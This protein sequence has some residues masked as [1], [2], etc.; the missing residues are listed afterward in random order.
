MYPSGRRKNIVTGLTFVKMDPRLRGET[1]KSPANQPGFPVLDLDIPARPIPVRQHPPLTR[2]AVDLDAMPAGPVRVAMDQ[3]RHAGASEHL[4]HGLFVD[5]HDLGGLCLD[6]FL[7][8]LA[9]AV[10]RCAAFIQRLGEEA[11]LP[12]G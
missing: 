5:V 8:L 2:T 1:I 12:F 3:A 9:Q 4:A 10:D 11:A 6:D 7:A